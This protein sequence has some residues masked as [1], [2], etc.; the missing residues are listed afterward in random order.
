MKKPRLL[1]A[2]AES[3]IETIIAVTIITLAVAGSTSLIRSS[4]MTNNVIGSKLVALNLALEG[5]EAVKN[6]RDTNYLRFSSNPASCWNKLGVTSVSGCTLPGAQSF[7]VGVNFALNRD[8][9]NNPF[10]WQLVTVDA[11][12]TGN[13]DLYEID[14]D[15]D[16]T[17]DSQIYA[18]SGIGWVMWNSVESGVYNRIV[19]FTDSNPDYI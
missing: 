19:T 15:S 6:I 7:R 5:I 9:V 14:T 10:E 4:I 17:F 1:K 16:G 2:R 18:Q 8:F 13:L 12:N 3:L 11:V